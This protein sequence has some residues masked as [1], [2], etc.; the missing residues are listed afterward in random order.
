[1][2]PK[3]GAINLEA[4]GELPAKW[5]NLLW[6]RVWRPMGTGVARFFLVQTY[7]N[8]INA[9]NDRKL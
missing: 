6:A 9:P 5:S 2:R 3:S 8:G 4:K 7:Q 1:M